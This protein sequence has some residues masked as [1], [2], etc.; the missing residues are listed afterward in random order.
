MLQGTQLEIECARDTMPRGVLGHERRDDE[1][2]LKFIVNR[3]LLRIGL[4]EEYPGTTRPFPWMSEIMDLEKEKN[5]FETRVI[6]HPTGGALSWDRSARLTDG[7]EKAR[8][9]SDLAFLWVRMHTPA[10]W[11][12]LAGQDDNSHHKRKSSI[13][14]PP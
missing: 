8:R 3:R 13:A 1:D 9:E 12:A 14:L 4:K 11:I 10:Q 6:E 5:F 7:N 2:W